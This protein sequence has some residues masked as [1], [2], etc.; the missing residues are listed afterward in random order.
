[1]V[2]LHLFNP[3]AQP[4]LAALKA[5]LAKD[6]LKP[7]PPLIELGEFAGSP[8]AVTEPV[9]PFKSL[10]DWLSQLSEG[11]VPPVAPLPPPRPV[12]AK[13]PEERF[14]EFARLFEDPKPAPAAPRPEPA[15]PRPVVAKSPEE[16]FDEFA[17]LFDHPQPAPA[18]PRREAVP[19]RPVAAPLPPVEKSDE[20]ARLFENPT[21]A[22][23]RSEPGEFTRFFG[24]SSPR[25]KSP[26]PTPQPR[27][28]FPAGFEPPPKAPSKPAPP[29]S[30][31]FTKM[32][33]G[34]VPPASRPQSP[35]P[36]AD[37]GQF[38]RLFGAG[39]SGEAIN[40]EEEQARAAKNAP[41]E[42]RP[43]QAPSEF[44]RVFGPDHGAGARPAPQS[45]PLTLGNA[46]GIFRSVNVRDLK[47]PPKSAVSTPG[48]EVPGEYTKLIA[49]GSVRDTGQPAAAQPLPPAA[50]KR[51]LMIGLSIFIGVLVVIILV[52][53]VIA[54]QKP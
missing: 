17:R 24:A 47:K 50:P 10:R 22:P 4:L 33:G 38:T 42:S 44:T 3:E 1:L 5:R 36:S 43:F 18:A 25:E 16:R 53:V 32:F 19:P 9:T 21:T 54:M 41:P 34:P 39:P 14:D 8:Y 28:D 49:R 12:V 30:D 31:E 2:F 15:P 27:A 29:E 26:A 7:T 37:T 20:F 52:V 13:S 11:T 35:A 46:S 48:E 51:G 6:P 40:I 23:P 45:R